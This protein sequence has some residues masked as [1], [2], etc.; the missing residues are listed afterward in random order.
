[1]KMVFVSLDVSFSFVPSTFPLS[2]SFLPFF[3]FPLPSPL[4]LCLP[5]SVILPPSFPPKVSSAQDALHSL[6]GS[7]NHHRIQGSSA[8]VTASNLSCIFFFFS[9]R[10][11]QIL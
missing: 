9:D 6:Q 3:H 5:S 4:S 10:A 8:L 1:M 11:S 7:Y 2:L